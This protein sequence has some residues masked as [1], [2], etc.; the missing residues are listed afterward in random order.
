M[1]FL[2][3]LSWF[4]CAALVVGLSGRA[5]TATPSSVLASEKNIR[6]WLHSGEPR[7]VAWGAHDALISRNPYLVVDLLSL[8]REWE[9]FSSRHSCDW[10]CDDL[11]AEEKEWRFAMAAVLDALIQMNVTVP[12]DSLHNLAPDFQ[13]AVA[14]LLA[15]LP[16]DDSVALSAG[17]A[18]C[19]CGADGFASDC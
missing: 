18:I 17:L 1:A 13:N 9:S 10:A 3:K 14:I 4:A 12:A 19:E 6:Q 15:R 8:A 7:F 2:G 5:Q 16:N 11:T